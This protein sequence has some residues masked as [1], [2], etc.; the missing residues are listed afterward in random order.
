MSVVLSNSF[1]VDGFIDDSNNKFVVTWIIFEVDVVVCFVV[2]GESPSCRLFST[3]SMLEWLRNLL[4]PPLTGEQ[5]GKMQPKYTWGC[6]CQSVLRP[7]GFL[8]SPFILN[9]FSGDGS[10]V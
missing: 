3:T 8:T 10:A 5:Y 1:V 2:W 4:L 7:M 9:Q 6:H